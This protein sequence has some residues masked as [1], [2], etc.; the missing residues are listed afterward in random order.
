MKRRNVIVDSAPPQNRCLEAICSYLVERLET[1]TLLSSSLETLARFGTNAV[2]VQPW[3]GFAVDASGNLYGTAAAGGTSGY[4][5]VFEIPHGTSTIVPVAS[6]NGGNG[7][8]PTGN[9]VMDAKGDLFGMTVSNLNAQSYLD[10]STVF[11]VAKGTNTI[12][13][14]GLIGLNSAQ[15]GG[16]LALDAE[17][18]L[19]GVGVGNGMVFEIPRGSSTVDDLAI[20]QG[21]VTGIV[22]DGN[23][24]VFG[25][26]EQGGANG[27]GSIFEVAHGSST[28][29]V[30]FSF[31]NS[32]GF[33]PEGLVSDGAGT[34]F[35]TIGLAGTGSAVY[36]INE[37]GS[38]FTTLASFSTPD[39]AG[40]FGALLSARD[41]AGNLY[42]VIYATSGQYPAP[43]SI[44][45]LPVGATSI[46]SLATFDAGVN[47]PSGSEPLTVD[48]EG[49]LYGAI[50]RAGS[51][52]DPG[53]VFELA[54]W[55]LDYRVSVLPQCQRDRS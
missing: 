47:S 32:T 13:T 43:Q 45:E 15:N 4:G 55:K 49:N 44:F 29:N 34:L 7:I 28:A 54:L 30:I 3:P 31:G 16:M 17:G 9:L 18:D 19:Y 23:G 6:F 39:A 38:G 1:R 41:G 20:A 14:V 22:V 40:L 35:G 12:T 37:D 25:T 27:Y 11:E 52:R 51:N 42:G 24:D 26:T 46:T 36:R 5:A 10:Q 48:S 33:Y 21:V 8:A 50:F 2:G 53:A